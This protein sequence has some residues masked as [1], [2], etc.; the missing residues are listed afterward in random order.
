MNEQ[1]LIK[2][3]A[4]PGDHLPVG[5]ISP[6]IASPMQI[7]EPS[8]RN[9]LKLLA[10]TKCIPEELYLDLDPYACVEKKGW[11]VCDGSPISPYAYPQLS[12]IL[13]NNLGNDSKLPDFTGRVHI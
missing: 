11:L 4:V 10:T 12:G 7:V 9:L 1:W 3:R 5:T 13:T 8:V 6:W 2:A